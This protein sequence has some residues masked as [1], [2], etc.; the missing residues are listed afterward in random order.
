MLVASSA[1]A[2]DLNPGDALGIIGMQS[3]EPR[4]VGAL[5]ADRL[6]AAE[7]DIVDERGVEPVAVADRP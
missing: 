7:N 1:E 4:D 5:L 2:V 3:G 6:D